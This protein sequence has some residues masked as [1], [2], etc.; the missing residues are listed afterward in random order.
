LKKMMFKVF[1]LKK[2]KSK[3][4]FK[5]VNLPVRNLG[6]PSICL[7]QLDALCVSDYDKHIQLI[8]DDVGFQ[9]ATSHS[10]P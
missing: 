2:N 3:F 1:F 6:L 4:E 7:I 8:K 9:Q 10:L 5:W